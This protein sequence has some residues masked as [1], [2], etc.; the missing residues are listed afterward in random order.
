M[1]QAT[2]VGLGSV[3]VDEQMFL[4]RIPAEDEKE[5]ATLVRRQIG[6]PVPTAL[7]VLRRFGHRCWLISPWGH[8]SAGDAIEHD[9][10]TTGIGFSPDCRSEH[11]HSGF[12][13]VWITRGSGSRTIVAHQ[14]TWNSFQLAEADHKALTNCRWLHLDGT[15]GELAM[16][17]ADTVRRHSGRIMVDAGSPKKATASLIPLASVFSFPERFAR[18]FFDT[19]DVVHAGRRVLQLGAGAAVCTRGAQ[20]AVV[21]VEDRVIH[22]PAFTVNT[23]DSTGAGD[24]FCGGVMAGLLDGESIVEAVRIGAAAAALKCQQVGNRSALPDRARIKAL[25]AKEQP[26][27]RDEPSRGE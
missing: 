5:H 19:D 3:V 16:A 21:F 13:H 11:R 24:V 20:G 9:L 27:T 6:G 18:Q 15:G 23:I 8:D 4:E 10:S 17:A 1:D 22:V 2:V 7:A 14:A 26:L 25:L 12:A